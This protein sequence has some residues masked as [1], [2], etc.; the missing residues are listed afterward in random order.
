VLEFGLGCN[1]IGRTWKV[2]WDE[3]KRR[4]GNLYYMELVS[5]YSKGGVD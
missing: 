4:K 5:G 3:M 1:W 2:D